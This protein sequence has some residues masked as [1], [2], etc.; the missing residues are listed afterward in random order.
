MVDGRR[1]D[2]RRTDGR[3]LDG[4][5]I[6][7]PCEP[8]GSVELIKHFVQHKLTDL[9]S[10]QMEALEGEVLCGQTLSYSHCTTE[11]KINIQSSFSIATFL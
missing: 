4:F 1:T 7:S 10:D 6:S 5:T 11:N 2:G 3:R 9:P 8:N